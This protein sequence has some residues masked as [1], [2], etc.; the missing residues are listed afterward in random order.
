MCIY[1]LPY[2]HLIGSDDLRLFYDQSLMT[3]ASNDLSNSATNSTSTLG[4]ERTKN[5]QPS[6]SPMFLLEEYEILSHLT[7]LVSPILALE[8]SD[9]SISWS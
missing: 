9:S 7:V 8:L 2:Q 5:E 3:V 6:A 4:A 1:S